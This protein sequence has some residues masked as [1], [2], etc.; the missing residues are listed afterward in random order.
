M[1][2]LYIDKSSFHLACDE[3][4]EYAFKNNYTGQIIMDAN[5][6][7]H[8]ET[9]VYPHEFINKTLLIS[10]AS[11]TQTSIY[12]AKTLRQMVL[13]LIPKV[14][15]TC[16]GGESY[17]YGILVSD[18]VFYTNNHNILM[19]CERNGGTE[20]YLIDYNKP[21]LEKVNREFC[22][23]NLTKL[24]KELLILLNESKILQILIINCHEDDFEKKIHLLSNY[25][26]DSRVFVE[27]PV[28]KIRVSITI[29]RLF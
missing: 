22:I 5:R 23:L 4:K 12:L 7:I 25:S 16:I 9:G 26:I 28:S 2:K 18:F 20:C 1:Q 24:V 8:T 19:D 27:C 6:V 13:S 14:P 10:S 3:I 29:C 11:F 21:V 15:I 17:G